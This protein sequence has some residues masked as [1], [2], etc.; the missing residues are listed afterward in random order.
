MAV[1]D[2]GQ[3]PVPHVQPTGRAHQETYSIWG[4][5]FQPDKRPSKWGL[6]SISLQAN[7]ADKGV[8][9]FLANQIVGI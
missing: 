4:K 1:F 2:L 3:G 5:I 8:P 7:G 6:R 9:C